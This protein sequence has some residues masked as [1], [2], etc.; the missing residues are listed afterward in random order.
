[1]KMHCFP[2]FDFQKHY[3]NL[4]R[5]AYVYTCKRYAKQEIL[6]CASAVKKVEKSAV[7]RFQQIIE[8]G[9]GNLL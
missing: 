7:F 2:L 5:M 4:M 8:R 3:R 9:Y 1:M 6:S